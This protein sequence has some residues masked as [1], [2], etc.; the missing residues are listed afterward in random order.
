MSRSLR[1]PTQSAQW[2]SEPSKRRRSGSSEPTCMSAQACSHPPACA[3]ARTFRTGSPRRSR[4]LSP[5]RTP[6]PSPASTTSRTNDSAAAES[7]CAPL[8]SFESANR[9]RVWRSQVV[10]AASIIVSDDGRTNTATTQAQ[11][12]IAKVARLIDANDHQPR[13]SRAAVGQVRPLKCRSGIHP[14]RLLYPPP[15]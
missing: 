6:V 4:R 13:L 2:R 12:T 5:S 7:I 10:S 9:R 14:E 11:R 15:R 3:V 8:I 1:A